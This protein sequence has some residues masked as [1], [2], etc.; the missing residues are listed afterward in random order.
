MAQS[1][2]KEKTKFEKTK[3]NVLVTTLVS[4][5]PI[6][7]LHNIHRFRNS[8]SVIWV[9]WPFPFLLPYV[10]QFES[11]WFFCHFE[12]QVGLT[13]AIR[14][15]KSLPPALKTVVE[16]F[17]PLPAVGKKKNLDSFRFYIVFSLCEYVQCFIYAFSRIE[18]WNRS[19]RWKR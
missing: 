7:M 17:V 18:R 5:T 11:L 12:H 15:A 2:V 1:K 19:S 16:R 13:M 3:L 10:D 8:P 6:E 9:L 4:I 14:R